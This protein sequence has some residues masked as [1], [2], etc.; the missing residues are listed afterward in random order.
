MTRLKLRF[1]VITFSIGSMF[2]FLQ[3]N[4][5]AQLT[6]TEQLIRK[7]IVRL[8]GDWEGQSK[9]I[10]VEFIGPRFDVCKFEML[11]HL[12]GLNFLSVSDCNTPTQAIHCISQIEDLK[13]LQIINSKVDGSSFSNLANCRN[14]SSIQLDGVDIS[15]SFLD[16]LI[17]LKNLRKLT[18]RNSTVPEKFDTEVAKMP[19][20][21]EFDAF[22]VVSV[23]KHDDSNS[24][25]SISFSF[26][27]D[28]KEE[29]KE[30]LNK[31]QNTNKNKVPEAKNES[32]ALKTEFKTPE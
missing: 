29:L 11:T 4:S 15:P 9:P 6:A 10:L 12:K 16:E 25:T 5:L 28:S 23:R 3:Q 1:S 26:D 31:R 17:K 18:V 7:E 20:L 27:F 19:S 30:Y 14:L 8:G 13:E 2:L 21:T 22:K 24:S 32:D